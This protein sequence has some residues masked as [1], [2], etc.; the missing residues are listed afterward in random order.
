MSRGTGDERPSPVSRQCSPCPWRP[1]SPGGPT[2]VPLFGWVVCA[3]S[4]FRTTK[5]RSIGATLP[6]A[7][8]RSRTSRR[9][10]ARTSWIRGSRR[11]GRARRQRVSDGAPTTSSRCARELQRPA[12]SLIGGGRDR[13]VSAGGGGRDRTAGRDLRPGR[14]REALSRSGLVPPSAVEVRASPPVDERG[15]GDLATGVGA[16]ERHLGP[17]RPRRHAEPFDAE[18]VVR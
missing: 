4:T 11:T 18:P 3:V 15:L 13:R 14:L 5:A 17:R 16:R 8:S 1:A 6:P 10:R 9:R 2:T 12:A 7:E